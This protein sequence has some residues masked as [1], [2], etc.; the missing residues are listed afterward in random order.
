[1]ARL[2]RGKSGLPQTSPPDCGILEEAQVR[3][4]GKSR[5]MLPLLLLLA[6]TSAIVPST[7]RIA[8]TRHIAL[9]GAQWALHNANGSVALA[10]VS[11]PNDA[12]GALMS[13][14]VIADPY[15]RFNDAAYAWVAA[16]NWTFSRRL[17]PAF[18]SAADGQWTLVC[19]GLQTLAQVTLDG[20]ELGR[21]DNQYRRWSFPLPAG[22]GGKML[23]LRFTSPLHL[24]MD[25]TVGHCGGGQPQGLRQEYLRCVNSCDQCAAVLL[26]LTA[27][28][29]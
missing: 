25:P 16:D 18:D 24:G 2:T 29:C 21:A 22:A 6:S 3:S 7:S 20:A 8:S 23:E 19:E 13:A 9:D 5:K 12:H 28:L 4:A 27:L 1:M 14:G 15:Y 10:S 26:P 17:P 11:V